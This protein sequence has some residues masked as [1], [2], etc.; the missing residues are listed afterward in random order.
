MKIQALSDPIV[1][2]DATSRVRIVR[3][4]ARLRHTE[5][6]FQMGGKT[7]KTPG[8]VLHCLP[9]SGFVCVVGRARAL[10]GSVRREGKTQVR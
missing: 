8:Q 9:S 10:W 4:Q 7:Q 1:F 2:A 3:W 5:R 6:S